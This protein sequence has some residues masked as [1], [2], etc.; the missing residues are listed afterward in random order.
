MGTERE[1]R[2]DQRKT[3]EALQRGAKTPVESTLFPQNESATER[4][5]QVHSPF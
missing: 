4:E 2:H 3:M 5:Q 1:K